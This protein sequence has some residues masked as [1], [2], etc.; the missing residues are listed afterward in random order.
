YVGTPHGVDRIEPASGRIRHFST[1][2]GLAA[3]MISSLYC[4]DAGRI[5]AGTSRGLSMLT[6]VPDRSSVPPRVYIT[7]LTVNGEPAAVPEP[8]VERVSGLRLR[9]DQR[10][11]RIAF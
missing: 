2:D 4:D 9:P 8:G 11:V 6:A 3:G 7:G 1:A 5:W 10:Q